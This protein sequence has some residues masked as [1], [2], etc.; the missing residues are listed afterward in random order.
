MSSLPVGQAAPTYVPYTPPKPGY[1]RVDGREVPYTPPS[2]TSDGQGGWV[3]SP[4]AG[5]TDTAKSVNKVTSASLGADDFMK[6]LVAQL[7][8]QDPTKPADTAQMMQQTASMGMIERVNE[9]ATSAEA[10]SKAVEALTATTQ[11]GQ[12]SYAAMLMEQ[13][14][15]SAVGLVGKTVTYADATNPETK[16]DGVVDSVRFDTAGPILIV[17]GKDVPLASV[18]GVKAPTGTTTSSSTAGTTT[19]AT[20]S[21]TA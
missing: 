2:V 16:V 5:M 6:L 4:A 14:M 15:S 17:G 8:Y 9:M 20:G 21:G 13:R 3:S 11:A 19:P 18:S 7:K 10:M 12:S 1:I